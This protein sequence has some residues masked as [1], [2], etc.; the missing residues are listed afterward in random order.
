M[1][2]KS[3]DE[4]WM[5]HLED[6]NLHADFKP[7][8]NLGYSQK[9]ANIITAYIIMSYDPDSSW[10]TLTRDRY[11]DK[12]NVLKG[13][14]VDETDGTF[15][16][17]FK[18]ILEYEND[19]VQEVILTFLLNKTDARWQETHS[20]LDYATKM[21]RFC[22]SRT[23][24]SKLTGEDM[25]KDTGAVTKTFEEIDVEK[26]IK[27]NENKGKLL[28]QALASRKEAELLILE[29]KKDFVKTDH[30]VQ[31]DFNF[32][33]SETAKEKI[34]IESWRQHI[35]LRNDRRQQPS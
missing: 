10:I 27:A 4:N 11:E 17:I 13:L 6:I 20:L 9:I 23:V 18:P 14:G 3:T 25:D 7:L 31:S 19:E 15:N 16:S 1:I 22:N 5:L 8:Y 21:I 24:E 28:S 12:L 32:N 29:I 34:K 35:R 33:F 30:A 2:M 26:V